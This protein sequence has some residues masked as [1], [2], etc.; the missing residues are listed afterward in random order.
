MAEKTYKVWDK[1]NGSR[2][3]AHDIE[4]F[5]AQSAA[6]QYADEDVDGHT[7]GLYADRHDICV[8]DGETVRT[9]EVIVDYS[10]T[11]YAAE[12]SS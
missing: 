6:E 12:K 7:D 4:A 1:L 3:T 2:E 9:F 10:P 5:D 11:F 8:L